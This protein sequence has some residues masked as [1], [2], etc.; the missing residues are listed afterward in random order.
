MVSEVGTWRAM[1]AKKYRK[2]APKC[3]RNKTP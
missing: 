2:D 3:V 1:S